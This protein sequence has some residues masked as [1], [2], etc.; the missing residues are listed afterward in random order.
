[1]ESSHYGNL[2]AALCSATKTTGNITK[3]TDDDRGGKEDKLISKKETSYMV[4]ILCPIK[5]IWP[6]PVLSNCTCLL[7]SLSHPFVYFYPNK[8]EIVLGLSFIPSE[9]LAEI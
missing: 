5:L 9:F 4:L 1:M 2:S 7:L 6:E 8:F 3:T